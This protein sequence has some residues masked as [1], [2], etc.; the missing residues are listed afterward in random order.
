MA[1]YLKYRPQDLDDLDLT[2]VRDYL[3]KILSQKNIPHAYLFTGPKGIGKTSAA[4]IVAKILNCQKKKDDTTPCNKCN[5]CL[6]ITQGTNIDV[7]EIDAASHRGIDDIR[8]LK[9]AVKLSPLQSVNKIFIVDEAHMLT[10]EASNALLKTLEEPPKHVYFILATTNPEKLIPTIISRTTEVKFNK[11]NT[12]ETE[13]VLKKI[14]RKE[15]LDLGNEIIQMIASSGDGS[16]RDSVKLLESIVMQGLVSVEDIRIFLKG[17]ST[18]IDD[19]I[20]ALLKRDERDIVSLVNS[21]ASTGGD[22]KVLTDT[23]IEKVRKE[24]EA[25]I[26]GTNSPF[27]KDELFILFDLLMKAKEQLGLSLSEEVPLLI[28]LIK[29]INLCGGGNKE[30]IQKEE[31]EVIEQK[32][33][34][35]ESGEITAL[36]KEEWLNILAA[37]KPINASIESLLRSAKPLG[38]V[39]NILS[40]GVYYSFHKDRLEEQKHRVILESVLTQIYS[41][42]MRVKCVLN[43]QTES[44]IT[45]VRSTENVALTTPM[46]SDIIDVAKKIFGV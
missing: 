30:R 42:P 10:T 12:T 14:I 46:G 26:A 7:V 9:D 18:I 25:I 5:N 33:D 40:I 24:L 23:L 8:A 34:I 16:F 3:K 37:V 41:L 1:Y 29:W 19:L 38:I 35:L 15:K 13:S 28:A 17:S 45:E 43:K 2:R 11:A 20:I 44:E 21:Q 22:I 39:N 31:V 32:E 6:T 4:R 36:G 27:S